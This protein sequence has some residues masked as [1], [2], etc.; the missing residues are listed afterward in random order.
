VHPVD[1][2]RPFDRQR[3]TARRRDTGS[4]CAIERLGV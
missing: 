3:R 1:G 4:S 2:S